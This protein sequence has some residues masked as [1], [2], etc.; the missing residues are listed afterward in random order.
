MIRLTKNFTYNEFF[1]SRDHPRLAEQSLNDAPDMLESLLRLHC[2]YILQPV[3]DDLRRGVRVTSGYRDYALNK[4]VG[5]SE[6]SL[7][8]KG[9]AVDF[10]IDDIFENGKQG[11]LKAFKFIRDTLTFGELRLY[12][13]K[14]GNFL[15]IHVSLPDEGKYK[16]VSRKVLRD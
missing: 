13:D 3:R 16:V 5:G 7:H 10:T 4:A 6:R 8:K 11:L 9:L 2:Y 12:E 15:F 1:V 14:Y